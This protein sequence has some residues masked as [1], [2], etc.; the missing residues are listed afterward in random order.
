[1]VSVNKTIVK[2][3]RKEQYVNDNYDLVLRQLM[4]YDDWT[5]LLLL[6]L[7]HSRV[8]FF[9]L[10]TQNRRMYVSWTM[11]A[12][13][14]VDSAVIKAR[15]VWCTTVCMHDNILADDTTW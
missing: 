10:K 5:F 9:F 4:L 3:L 2:Q 13:M 15:V 12:V 7:F 1:M 6:L 8:Q 11:S 14:A